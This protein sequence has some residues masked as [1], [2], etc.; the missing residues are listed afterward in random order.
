MKTAK[1]KIY[2]NKR[3]E[4]KYLAVKR[5]DCGHYYIQGFVYWQET[6]V[7]NFL[8]CRGNNGRYGRV[9]RKYTLDALLE[10]Y[11]AD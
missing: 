11:T 3:N 5:Y 2:R 10:D 9:T 6:G 4:N 7:L 1:V 8:G